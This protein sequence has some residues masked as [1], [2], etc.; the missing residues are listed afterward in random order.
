MNGQEFAPTGDHQARD[1]T[2]W[3]VLLLCVAAAVTMLPLWEPL[4]LAAFVA[5]V[6]EPLY[7]R[8]YRRIDGR[9]SSAALITL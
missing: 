9:A 4:L 5:V 1:A 2:R 3:A 7:L 6:A 8:L